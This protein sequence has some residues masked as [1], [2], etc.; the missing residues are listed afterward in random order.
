MS[1]RYPSL[2]LEGGLLSGEVIDELVVGGLPG[3][4]PADFGFTGSRPFIDEVAPIWAEALTQWRTFRQAVDRLKPEDSATRETRDRWVGPLLSLLGYD[5]YRLPR[6][7][8]AD[9]L[10]FAFSHRAG[11]D[12][13]G[14]PVHIV[15]CRQSLDRRPESGRPRLGPHSLVQEFLNRTEALWGIATNG[16]VLRLLRDSHLIRRQSYVEFDLAR[17]MDEERFADF[18]L[19]VRLLHASRLPRT[20]EDTKDCLLE[21]YHRTTVEQGGRVRDHLREGVDRALR[22]I[23]D[24]LL[25][26]RANEALRARVVSGELLPFDYYQQLLKL[27]YRLLFLSVSEERGLVSDDAQYRKYYSISRLRQLAEVRA[28]YTEQRDLWEGLGVTFLLFGNEQAGAALGVPPLGGD[29]FDPEGLLGIHGFALSNRILLSA[30][31]DLSMYREKEK[32][33]WRRINYGALDVEELGSVYES[34]L[35]FA[36]VFTTEQGRPGFTLSA[37]TERKS[38]G[39]YYTPPELVN[40]LVQSALVPVIEERLAAAK[41]PKEKEEALLSL[42]VCDPACGSGHFLLAAARRIGRE[43]A[44]SRTGDEEPSPE[45]QRLAVRDVIT[46]NIYG[47]DK[48]PLAVDLCRVALWLEGHSMGR[49]LTFLNHRIRCGDSLVGVYDLAVLKEGIP[50]AAYT[51]VTGDDKAVA[52]AV[53]K[54]NKLERGGQTTLFAVDLADLGPLNDAR[55]RLSTIPDDTPAAVREKEVVYRTAQAEGTAWCRDRT[56]CDLW[57]AAFFAPLTP[58]TDEAGMIPTTGTVRSYLADDQATVHGE[59]A[60]EARRISKRYRFFHWPLEFPE[61]FAKGGFDCVLGNPPWERIKLQQQ[62][63]FSTRDPAIA[64]AANKA[65]RDKFI[66]ALPATNSALWDDYLTELHGAEVQSLILRQGGR[67]PL[68]GRGDINTY[69]VFTELDHRLINPRGMTGVICPPGIASDDTNK[70]FFS[71]IIENQRLAS[72]IAFVNE[73]FIFQGV[74]HNFRFCIITMTGNDIRNNAPEF[75]YECQCIEDIRNQDRKFTLKRDDFKRLNPNTLTAPVFRTNVDADISKKIYRRIPV[76]INETSE[77]NPWEISFSRMFDM[78]NDSDLFVN[79]QRD[80]YVPLFESKMIHQ[81]DHRYASFHTLDGKRAHMLP[82]VSLE[83]HERPSFVTKPCYWVSESAV[84]SRLSKKWNRQFH[85]C[86]RRVSSKSLERTMIACIVPLVATNDGLPQLIIGSRKELLSLLIANLNSIPFDFCARQKVGS[87]HLDYHCLKQLPVIPPDCYTPDDLAFIVPRVLEL[88]Y[89]AWDIKAFADD[90]W[91]DADEA[92]RGRLREQWAANAAITGGHPFE[93]PAWA[94]IAEDGCPLPPFVWDE[95]RRAVLRA[96]LDALYARLYGLTRDELRY[97]LDPADV[98]GEEFP[99][100]TF[101]VLK[102]K[103]IKKYG[104]YR[105]RRLVLEA[106]DRMERDS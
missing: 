75:V 67:F 105:T 64:G 103:E 85:L 80:G 78:S 25:A 79:T 106:W 43:L 50:D 57:T 39:S 26:H 84:F 1:T 68:T 18:A 6:A 93:P 2:R 87:A 21:R 31:W 44:R 30:I 41:T 38:T 88:T 62:E 76:L 42:A 40:E 98:Y 22:T 56:A 83:E 60:R 28:A 74:L 94:E 16:R 63:F 91:R 92:M 70:I 53:K 71:D 14:P 51:A 32:A 27:I 72:L 55:R 36:P 77:K 35:D 9:G 65:T 45:E 99:G 73:K 11:S 19:F 20:G 13:N 58:E 102:E 81:Y 47:V 3:Q 54:Q 46:H 10:S 37:G 82:Q 17:M 101:R 86:Y 96:E 97:I 33:P 52:S 48:N 8:E 15:G 69:A 61:V 89:S 104:E 12:E 4:K 49:P 66:A 90:V 24:G 59:A 34:L 100:E 7:A 23:G 5:L 29:L 95:E